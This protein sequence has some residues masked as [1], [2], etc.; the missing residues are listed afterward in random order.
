M[1]TWAAMVMLFAIY[2]A[3]AQ[4]T[5]C[6]SVKIQIKR[7]LTFER[8][9]FDATMQINKTPDA[10]VIQNVSALV[11]VTADRNDGKPPPW[12]QRPSPG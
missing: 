8:R 3:Y 4:D 7:R 2:G 5:V 1:M 12:N 10:G 6:A 9:A 11:D